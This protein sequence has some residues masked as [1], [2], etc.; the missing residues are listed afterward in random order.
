[1]LIEQIVANGYKLD[2]RNPHDASIELVGADSTDQ[3]D[4]LDDRSCVS[5]GEGR[6]IVRPLTVKFVS[7]CCFMVWC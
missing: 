7:A 1:M 4:T 5:A 2:I 3:R 6:G